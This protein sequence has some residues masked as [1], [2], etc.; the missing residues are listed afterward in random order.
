MA[1][2]EDLAELRAWMGEVLG[3]AHLI[4]QFEVNAEVF[5]ALR[6]VKR[7]EERRRAAESLEISDARA[8]ASELNAGSARL[9]RILGNSGLQNPGNDRYSTLLAQTAVEVG[10]SEPSAAAISLRLARMDA[11]ARCAARER[12]RAE[13]ERVSAF[14]SAEDRLHSLGELKSLQAECGDRLELHRQE[15]A[16]LMEG[17]FN[18]MA[19]KADEY[20]GMVSS[21]QQELKRLG[22][23]PS[24]SH[25]ALQA[26]GEKLKVL[27]EELVRV[28]RELERFHD[29]PLSVEAARI[30]TEE[31][32]RDVLRAEEQL[33]VGVERVGL[34]LAFE[35][36][37]W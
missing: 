31:V 16:P 3:G 15:R 5:D 37:R 4:P 19:Q 6:Q 25:R 28:D 22:Y 30:R 33:R 32:E 8:M 20:L 21:R 11:A 36:D 23:D 2:E 13:T 14:T 7:D 18:V 26:K 17:S 12:T 10:A 35:D 1:D 24:I 9:R 27:T 29:L 34:N